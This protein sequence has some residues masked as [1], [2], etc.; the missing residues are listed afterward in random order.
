M[1]FNTSISKNRP[2]WYLLSVVFILLVLSIYYIPLVL[3][4]DPGF[5]FNVWQSMQKG[6]HFNTITVSDS[7]VISQG[8]DVFIAWWSPGQY[9][10][11]VA[12]SS[13]LNLTYERSCLLITI[14]FTIWGL[15]GWYKIYATQQYHSTVIVWSLFFILTSRSVTTTQF[16]NYTG[17][18]ILFFGGAPWLILCYLKLRNNPIK[19][20]VGLLVI[21]LVCFVFKTSSSIV[22]LSLCAVPFLE[23]IINCISQKQLALPSRNIITV[24]T[25]CCLAFIVY[26]LLIHKLYLSKG[27]NPTSFLGSSF[28]FNFGIID[29][30]NLP[31]HY[32]LSSLDFFYQI[33]FKG[34]VS[35]DD[36]YWVRA[37]L[38]VS[39]MALI[40]RLLWSV[41]KNQTIKPNV[42]LFL[43]F[44]IIYTLFMGYHF[45][46]QAEISFDVRHFKVL[47]F[48]FL[49]I[50]LQNYFNQKTIFYSLVFILFMT[51]TVYSLV[52]FVVKKKEISN[53]PISKDGFAL[54]L[55]DQS[56]IDI[57]SEV[58]KK[59]NKNR[60]IFIDDSA[61][62]LNVSN[63]Q[64]IVAVSPYTFSSRV[65]TSKLN[66]YVVSQSDTIFAFIRTQTQDI[67]ISSLFHNGSILKTTKTSSHFIYEIIGRQP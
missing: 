33:S 18:E 38:N 6:S 17:G 36:I 55:T 26:Y 43:A 22:L 51:N 41:W 23:Y 35:I 44:Y 19:L 54:K 66:G 15:L 16:L 59:P 39:V 40:I 24:A 30:L 45:S 67:P 29:L 58:D 64:K 8:K 4:D 11:P 56:C 46:R 61:L 25:A 20:F 37:L 60:T 14:L 21:S 34:F 42:A 48:L 3:G 2:I 62:A 27:T 52:I 1:V 49:P 65:G 7:S 47:A 31:V 32:W 13:L 50:L 5:G 10:V 53:Y 12:I 28:D 57:M 63:C 9:L